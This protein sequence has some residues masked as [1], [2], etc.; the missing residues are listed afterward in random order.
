MPARL[1][2]PHVGHRHRWRMPRK[3]SRTRTRTRRR[4]LTCRRIVGHAGARLRERYVSV[5]E[6]GQNSVIEEPTGEP[7][8][9]APGTHDPPAAVYEVKCHEKLTMKLCTSAFD[10][11]AATDTCSS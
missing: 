11:D 7:D 3:R 9:E 10:R 4:N 6:R 5:T 8:S 1:Q 2:R